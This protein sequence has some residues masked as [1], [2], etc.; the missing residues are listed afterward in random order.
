MAE[1][2]TRAEQLTALLEREQ[3]AR[4][5]AMERA[6][7]AGQEAAVLAV[8]LESA[9][10]EIDDIKEQAKEARDDARRAGEAAA[11]LRGRLAADRSVEL[12]AWAYTL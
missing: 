5:E 11:E 7:Q 8:K 9:A 4:A 2:H 6:A 12:R 10:R 3:A 1:S